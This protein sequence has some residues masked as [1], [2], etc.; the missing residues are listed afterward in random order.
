MRKKEIFRPLSTTKCWKSKINSQASSKKKENAKIVGSLN[1]G[2]INKP[3]DIKNL[4]IKNDM[5]LDN[6]LTIMMIIILLVEAN[7]ISASF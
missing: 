5:L 7:N 3:L 4:H 1:T 2:T 6:Q